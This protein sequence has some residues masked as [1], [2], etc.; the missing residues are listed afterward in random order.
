VYTGPDYI[1]ESV[2][3]DIIKQAAIDLNSDAAAQEIPYA[4]LLKILS[5]KDSTHF[6]TEV[7]PIIVLSEI[8]G[9]YT[10]SLEN[11]EFLYRMNL[12]SGAF[13]ETL[14]EQEYITTSKI[15]MSLCFIYKQLGCP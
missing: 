13:G 8:M 10:V 1:A 4:V 15:L 7:N 14:L 11:G 5:H 6:I 3:E 9:A 12:H 2:V